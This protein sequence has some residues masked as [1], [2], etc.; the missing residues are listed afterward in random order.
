MNCE[1]FTET[2]LG[3]LTGYVEG[4][5]FVNAYFRTSPVPKIRP[6]TQEEVE[7][8]LADVD[9]LATQRHEHEKEVATLLS[10]CG[11]TV[12]DFCRFRGVEL[13]SDG[14]ELYV[15]TRENGVEGRS[16]DAIRNPNYKSSGRDDGDSTYENYVF[17]VP[18]EGRAK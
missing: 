13:S 2:R 18:K 14:K 12:S 6:A 15:W 9:R 17:S 8:Y 1:Y 5:D 10:L 4:N 3:G 7:K 11:L 16:V